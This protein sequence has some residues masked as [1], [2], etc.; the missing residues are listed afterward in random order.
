[1][2][3]TKN[4]RYNAGIIKSLGQEL[5]ELANLLCQI[6][7]ADYIHKEY[8]AQAVIEGSIGE[9]VRHA[10]DH[11]LAVLHVID[12]LRETHSAPLCISY[13]RRER[14]TAIERERLLCVEKIHDCIEKVKLI[15]TEQEIDTECEADIYEVRQKDLLQKDILQEDIEIEHMTDAE[16]HYAF[17]TSNIGRE[18]MFICHHL[19]HHKAVIAIKLR[20]IAR[21]LDPAFGVAPAT[22]K[23][24]RSL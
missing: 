13:D 20:L 1:M 6:S 17:F 15:A 2:A 21:S 9:H 11:I 14:K 8:E 4:N 23:Q 3:H 22:R 7:D 12:E 10:L 18:L 19:I 16:G 24:A 5:E